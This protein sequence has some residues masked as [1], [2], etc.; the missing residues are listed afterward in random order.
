M[1]RKWFVGILLTGSPAVLFFF[2]FFPRY[3]ALN[4][5]SVDTGQVLLCA[6]MK[7]GEECVI[8]FIH[9]VNQRPVFDTLRME[10][11]HLVIVRS[12]FDSFGAGMPE[13]STGGMTLQFDREGWLV[14]TVNRRV[15][16]VTFFVGRVADHTLHLKGRRLALADL[17]EPGSSV[18]M[19]PA[20]VS[21]YHLRRG[22]CLR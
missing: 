9:S 3:T 1:M 17:S 6:E 7:E 19:R 12:R 11:D 10:G 8:S 18:S 20:R 5:L 15:P 16:E 2:L 21:Y 4:I 22:G 14:W 13:T